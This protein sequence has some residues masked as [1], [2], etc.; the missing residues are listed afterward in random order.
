MSVDTVECLVRHR[1]ILG[2][3]GYTDS[4]SEEDLHNGEYMYSEELERW[5]YL[6]QMPEEKCR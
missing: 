5:V 1:E 4:A 6:W 3:D 2:L